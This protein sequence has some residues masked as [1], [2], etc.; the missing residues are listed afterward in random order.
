MGSNTVM[1]PYILVY[2][3]V[4]IEEKMTSLCRY[5]DLDQPSGDGF[6]LFCS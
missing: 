5:L 3:R 1:M 2:N 6:K 4:Q